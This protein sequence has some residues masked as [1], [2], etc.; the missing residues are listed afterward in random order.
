M[1][2]HEMKSK[3]ALILSILAWALLCISLLTT[4]AGSVESAPPEAEPVEDGSLPGDDI[5]ATEYAYYNGP[6]V[7]YEITDDDRATLEHII[8][9]EAGGESYEGKLW[10]ATC[11]LNAMRLEDMTAEE[12]RTAYQYA[13]WS[14]TVSDETV[15]AVSAVFD[16][17]ETTHD[18][19]LWFYAPKYCNGAWHETQDY[20]T[21][22]GGHKFFAPKEE[23]K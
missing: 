5:P 14:E 4:P 18:T 22:V 20:I 23:T 8:S 7:Y 11:L 19:V 12:V 17:G 13:G 15:K 9:G 6:L 1:G 21:T 10:V 16:D 3:T 2:V